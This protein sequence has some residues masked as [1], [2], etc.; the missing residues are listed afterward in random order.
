MRTGFM[1]PLSLALTTTFIASLG[2]CSAAMA[3]DALG[4]GDALDANS[5]VGSGGRNSPVGGASDYRLRN[6]LITGNVAGG[7]GF[8][9]SVGYT[10]E[11]DFRGDLGS[12]EFFN[13]RAS[14][15][16]SD[17]AYV[18]RYPAANPLI[19]GQNFGLV[20]AQRDSLGS[21]IPRLGTMALQSGFELPNLNVVDTRL[22][23]T[24]TLEADYRGTTGERLPMPIGQ[25]ADQEGNPLNVTVSPLRG[26]QVTPD[27]SDPTRLGLTVFDSARLIE[28]ARE[29]RLGRAI[30]QP[31]QINA[32]A[33]N[34]L[35]DETDPT[36][37]AGTGAGSLL[38]PGYSD[39]LSRVR[40]RMRQS[41]I[42]LDPDSPEAGRRVIDELGVMQQWLATGRV[43]LPSSPVDP[44]EEPAPL[45]EL[46]PEDIARRAD[47]LRHGVEISTLGGSGLTRFD[48]LL[49]RGETQLRNGNYF[50]AERAFS[51]SLRMQPNHPLALAGLANSQVGAGLYLAAAGTLRELFT[52]H[53]ELI[54]AQYDD[55]LLPPSIRLGQMM[56][57][58]AGRI[59]EGRSQSAAGLVLA[60][61]GRQTG[62]VVAVTR[63][64]AALHAANEDDPL[65]PVL[66]TIW[67]GQVP[68][69][70]GS[71]SSS[72]NSDGTTGGGEAPV[73]TP[74]K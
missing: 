7:R 14:S 73:E 8:R 43:P 4:G 36:A 64:L 47:L 55:A 45:P 70:G 41:G 68:A 11:Y 49:Q 15:A 19:T 53:P 42:D 30:G 72:S 61:L 66:R 65:V 21:T 32:D 34:E 67:L 59:N 37:G 17:L 24:M 3:Q 13:F 62:D 74:D 71:G 51:H 54:D 6:L 58:L 52:R 40:D 48:E 12:D 56:E 10:S 23:R 9:G 57:H 27:A 63:G 28:D 44:G 5:Q 35:D 46:K 69:G 20:E 38:P 33:I 22:D 16:Y 1:R 2:V 39:I 31:F 26:V 60:Y 29:G 50:H 18:T 25:L